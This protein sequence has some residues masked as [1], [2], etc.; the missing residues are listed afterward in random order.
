MI[1]RFLLLV[2]AA[3]GIFWLMRRLRSARRAASVS[4]SAERQGRMVRDRVCNKFLP[5][6]SALTLQVDSEEHYFCSE[7]CRD[8]FLNN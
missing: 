2:L 4:K 8:R 5:R 7:A 3:V 6:S 1:R